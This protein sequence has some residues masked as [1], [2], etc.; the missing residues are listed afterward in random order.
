M[1][2]KM[3]ETAALTPTGE[4][5]VEPGTRSLLRSFWQSTAGWGERGTRASSVLSGILL[6]IV[7]VSLVVSYSMNVWNRAI[8]DA[9]EKRDSATVLRAV[10]SRA[11]DPCRLCWGACS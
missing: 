11:V 5:A 9:L 6:H 8:F 1:L 7:L 3:R 2:G 10:S 4:E